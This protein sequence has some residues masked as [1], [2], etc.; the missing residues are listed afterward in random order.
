MLRVRRAG[1]VT[2]L[3]VQYCQSPE[4]SSHELAH[5]GS[6]VGNWL[7]GCRAHA[8]IGSR[9]HIKRMTRQQDQGTRWQRLAI[10]AGGRPRAP[11]IAICSVL[12]LSP[13]IA[14]NSHPEHQPNTL[15]C[16]GFKKT[17]DGT[18]FAQKPASFQIGDV[19]DVIM[20]RQVIGP[21]SHKISGIDLYVLLER[22][23][24]GA[25]G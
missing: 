10:R 13:A 14:Q 5:R 7:F 2:E 21:G 11:A 6:F 15:R 22:K 8:I 18:W 20:E 3:V 23:C 1:R 19:K 24:A 9:P 16:E 25:R 17:L 4:R 12:S